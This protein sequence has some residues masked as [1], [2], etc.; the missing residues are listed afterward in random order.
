LGFGEELSPERCFIILPKTNNKNAKPGLVPN[1]CNPSYL[2]GG[3]RRIEIQ[4]YAR[5]KNETLTISKNKPGMVACACDP[6]Y[7]GGPRLARTKVQDHIQ[8]N[9]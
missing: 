4:G 2:G 5:Q 8:K 1:A 6:S 9:N 3:D 7:E